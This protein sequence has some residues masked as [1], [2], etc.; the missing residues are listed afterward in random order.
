MTLGRELAKL[1]IEGYD[2]I[3]SALV[4]DFKNGLT[5]KLSSPVVSVL[6]EGDK[7]LQSKLRTSSNIERQWQQPQCRIVLNYIHDLDKD[8]YGDIWSKYLAQHSKSYKVLNNGLYIELKFKDEE[9][10]G[11]AH[12]FVGRKYANELSNGGNYYTNRLLSI[13]PD[14]IY[15]NKK[16]VVVI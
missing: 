10:T 16:K 2:R 5:D 3:K 14:G 12:Y 15:L 13:E 11:I 7:V 8:V 1:G 6:I 4:L 9:S